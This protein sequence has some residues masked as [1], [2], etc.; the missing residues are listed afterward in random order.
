MGHIR[1]CGGLVLAAGLFVF[2]IAA[3]ADVY[4]ARQAY[5]KKDFARSF[6]LYRELAEIGNVDA[7]ESLAV[8]YVNGEG[9]KRDNVLGL[10]LGKDRAGA[11]F[12]RGRPEHRRSTRIARDRIRTDTDHRTAGAVREGGAA[13]VF[14]AAPLSTPANAAAEMQHA[15]S[16]EPG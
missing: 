9:V 2:S 7:Q 10:R 8:M 13:E 6:E 1:R 11:G 16:R 5:E 15:N 3:R 12:E 14:A 4:E